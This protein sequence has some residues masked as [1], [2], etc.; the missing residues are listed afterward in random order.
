MSRV[1]VPL[2]AKAAVDQLVDRQP[3]TPSSKTC[4]LN[5]SGL[6][7]LG[8]TLVVGYLLEDGVVGSNP[9]RLA[10]ASGSSAWLST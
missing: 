8:E 5:Y 7:C 6:L 4:L 9:T 10:K 1:R 3:K 2:V